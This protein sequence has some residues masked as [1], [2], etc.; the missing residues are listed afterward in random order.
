MFGALHNREIT[1]TGP[2]S[3]AVDGYEYGNLMDGGYVSIMAYSSRETNHTTR[4]MMFSS[5]D[6]VFDEHPTGTAENDARLAHVE[7]RERMAAVGDETGSCPAV[8]EDMGAN[9]I[10]RRQQLCCGNP[11][12]YR[13][14]LKSCGMC[15]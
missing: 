13:I 12:C 2:L 15:G 4:I 11:A 7:R 1:R 8:C 6:L 3:L 14:C 10:C 9:I 5:P